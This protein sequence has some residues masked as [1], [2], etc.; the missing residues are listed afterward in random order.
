MAAW[1]VL[2][3]TVTVVC[4]LAAPACFSLNEPN[5]AFTCLNPPHLC[6]TNYSCGTDFLCHRNGATGPC[7]VT[8]PGDGAADAGT[9][10]A[11]E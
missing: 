7:A 5:C 8:P 10:D 3:A 2:F 4:L 9:D 1:R 11:A 6:P